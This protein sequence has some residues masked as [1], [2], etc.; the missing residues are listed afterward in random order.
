MLTVPMYMLQLYDRVLSTGSGETLLLLSGLAV[1]LLGVQAILNVIRSRILV[2]VAMRLETGLR[3]KIVSIH[4]GSATRGRFTNTQGLDDLAE[5]RGFL[6]GGG[7]VTLFDA[8]WMPIYIGVIFLFHPLLGWIALSGALILL[9]IAVGG[10]ALTRGVMRTARSH[11]AEQQRTMQA[12]MRNAEIIGAMGNRE[13]LIRQWRRIADRALSSWATGSDRAGVISALAKYVRLVLQIA[14]LGAGV[15]LAIGHEITPG[16]II[17]GSIIMAR[18]LAPVEGAIVGWRAIVSARE[19]ARRLRALLTSGDLHQPTITIPTASGRV[20]VEK[21]GYQTPDGDRALLHG[22]NF[23]LKPGEALG[24]TG[25]SGSGKT[26]LARLLVGV[27]QPTAGA[28]RLD[29]ARLSHL[30]EI[31]RGRLIGYMQQDIQLF[32]GKIWQNIARLDDNPKSEDVTVAAQK[33]YF[34]D[35]VLDMPNGYD[36]DI[37]DGGALLSGGQQRMLGLARA[38][39]GDPKLLVLDEPGAGLDGD[40]QAALLRA[41][42]GTKAAGVT[43]IV[44]SHQPSLHIHMDTM[45]LLHAGQPAF[46]GPRAEF[47]ARFAGSSAASVANRAARTGAPSGPAAVPH[48]VPI[49]EME[50][51]R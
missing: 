15:G 43:V 33:A 27:M 13:T 24:I 30:H 41:I 29:G 25:P 38:F 2:R 22:V 49:P 36:T 47:L 8:P 11:N 51:Q 50:G 23:T 7:L 34:H 20:T 17:A 31:N 1:C 14:M 18:G 9:A 4:L 39:Y 5:V 32:A 10:S 3:E 35:R 12:Y 21:L 16:T 28:I 42:A 19:A 45:L 46:Y 26:T 6:C 40:G 48:L 44:I 37:G